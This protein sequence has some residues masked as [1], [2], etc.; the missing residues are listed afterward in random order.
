MTDNLDP[1]EDIA[2]LE[3]V[4]SLYRE[5]AV[6]EFPS[7]SKLSEGMP[8]LLELASNNRTLT[9]AT[10][11]KF[12]SNAEEVRNAAIAYL[13]TAYLQHDDNPYRVLGLSPWSQMEEVKK[14]HRFLINLFHPD[15]GLIDDSEQIGYAAKINQAYTA[16]SNKLKEPYQAKRYSSKYDTEI[17]D[18]HA[19]HHRVY[20]APLLH[21]IKLQAGKVVKSVFEIDFYRYLSISLGLLKR[22]TVLLYGLLKLIFTY[23]YRYI[24]FTVRV[25]RHA[26]LFLAKISAVLLQ[27]LQQAFIYFIQFII[28]FIVILRPKL[29]AALFA[30]LNYKFTSFQL[31]LFA[32]TTL[33]ASFLM[34]GGIE[35]SQ[36]AYID[37]EQYFVARQLAKTEEAALE[38][39]AQLIAQKQEQAS[40]E[41]ER[42]VKQKAEADRKLV[43]KQQAEIDA[44]LREANHKLVMGQEQARIEAEYMAAKKAESARRLALKQQQVRK[45]AERLA[46]KKAEAARQLAMKKEL[47]RKKAEKAESARQLAL[48]QEQARKEAERLAAEKAEAARQLAMKEELARKE[49]ARIEAEKAESARQ[50][51][52]K[53][54]QARKEAE[55][56]AAVKAEAARQLAMK[57]EL[58]RK[59]AARIEAEKAESAR[60]LALKQEQ[61]RKETERLAAEKA[62]AA[63][64]LAM[65]EELARKEAEKAETARQI[66]QKNEASRQLTES[67]TTSSGL[68]KK[69]G[70]L[71]FTK[72]LIDGVVSQKQEG[73]PI[74]DIGIDA[75]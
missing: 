45:E 14:R 61:A 9:D 69:A 35:Y 32:V 29:A 31:K 34:A 63:R 1:I 41:A 72:V 51:A 52:L 65:K 42:V 54:E 62:E 20:I 57:E 71:R 24:I 60:Q 27:I 25:L 39:S 30:L 36:K 66:A 10:L 4:L 49:A 55:R 23:I 44:A 12:N 5:K 70:S 75:Q 58:A 33:S 48:K 64:Q 18:S 67:T 40:I 47:A 22:L 21:W 8:F 19:I 53:Q 46:A 50:L 73:K 59:E 38:Q 16:I 11:K 56:L 7:I 68:A 2:L 3:Q 28:H 17:D 15:K 26:M 37:V 43:L 6:K 13:K 74:V